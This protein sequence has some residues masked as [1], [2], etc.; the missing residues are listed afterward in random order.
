[1]S[2]D[3]HGQLGEWLTAYLDGELGDE[4]RALIERRLEED[5]SARRLLDDLRQT[6]DLVGSLPRHSAPSSILDDLQL[7]AERSELLSGMGEG[8]KSGGGAWRPI[9]AVLS[10]AAVVSLFV[11]GLQLLIG[12]HQPGS[13]SPGDAIT[14][15]RNE[16][17]ELHK[18][19]LGGEN[20]EPTSTRRARARSAIPKKRGGSKGD[21]GYPADGKGPGH[22]SKGPELG[23]ASADAS[24]SEQQKESNLLAT[25]SF[26]QKL[27]AGLGMASVRD[28][29]FSNETVRMNVAVGDEAER[30]NVTERLIAYLTS[31][32]VDDLGEVLRDEPNRAASVGSFYYPG[33][34][35]VNY[36]GTG[37]RQLLVRATRRELDG[38]ISELARCIPSR[39]NVALVAGPLSIR[40]RERARAA[41]YVMDEPAPTLEPSPDVASF[42]SRHD[43]SGE[44]EERTEH[45]FDGLIRSVGVDP[46]LLTDALVPESEP[47]KASPTATAADSVPA[48]EPSGEDG[49]KKASRPGAGAVTNRGLGRTRV[50]DHRGDAD[51]LVESDRADTE[52]PAHSSA[53]RREAERIHSGREVDDE[54]TTGKT[55]ADSTEGGG[56]EGER[57]A[58]LIEERLSLV[59]RRMRTLEEA[60]RRD[61]APPYLA[62]DPGKSPAVTE[63]DDETAHGDATRLPVPTYVTLIVEIRVAEPDRRDG[64]TPA[65]RGS[66]TGRSS[67]TPKSKT[68]E[69][70]PSKPADK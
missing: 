47:A 65:R 20:T 51:P 10:M 55:A 8:Q 62:R 3:Q 1:M 17:D 64:T 42:A 34:S 2:D 14:L 30:D 12:D 24:A 22:G 26:N 69:P 5:A 56:K 36:T 48:M 44:K 25:A 6:A 49:V 70:D 15:A 29:S 21:A 39:D 18:G 59:E 46:S 57:G 43:R 38:L 68:K 67:Q 7:H 28:H 32:R 66:R 19:E 61:L 58:A 45:V 4:Q 13:G 33:E 60:D 50:T 9:V 16:T 53:A 52:E 35:N 37:K 31:R 40:G 54:A 27:E 41:L 23:L 63:T 11:V